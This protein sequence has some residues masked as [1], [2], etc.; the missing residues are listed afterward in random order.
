[1]NGICKPES[2]M[3]VFNHRYVVDHPLGSHTSETDSSCR[4]LLVLEKHRELAVA[5]AVGTW[6][7]SAHD[8]SDDELQHAAF[9]MLEH[10]LGMPELEKWRLSAGKAALR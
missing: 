4:E 1:M 9:L 2:V 7:F 8:F 6:A 3:D 10:A 5:E